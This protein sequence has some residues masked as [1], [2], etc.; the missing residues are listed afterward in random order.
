MMDTYRV[1]GLPTVECEEQGGSQRDT[2]FSARER[3]REREREDVYLNRKSVQRT[4]CKE[5]PRGEEEEEEKEEEEEE[6]EEKEGKR[7]KKRAR[8]NVTVRKG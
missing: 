7:G 6:K 8:G 4:R 1:R 3:E 2:T 5:K